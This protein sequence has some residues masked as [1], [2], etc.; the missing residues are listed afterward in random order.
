VYLYGVYAERFGGAGAPE[1]SF[2][3]GD[4]VEYHRR[5]VF[6]AMEEAP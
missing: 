5:L 2:F 1:V 4:A 3:H 6:D